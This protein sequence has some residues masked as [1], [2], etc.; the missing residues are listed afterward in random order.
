MPQ[1]QQRSRVRVEEEVVV[2]VEVVAAPLGRAL[3]SPRTCRRH[4][5]LSILYHQGT[6]LCFAYCARSGG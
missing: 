3:H 5:G 2:E 4:E 6:Y 1:E